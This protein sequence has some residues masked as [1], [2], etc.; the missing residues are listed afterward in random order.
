MGHTQPF[1]FV[2]LALGAVLLGV[3]V[4]C[5]ESLPS[6]AVVDVLRVIALTTE[7]PEVRPGEAVTVRTVWFDPEGR[8]VKFHWRLCREVSGFDP[9]ECAVPSVGRSLDE[10]NETVTLEASDLALEDGETTGTW[11]LWEMVCPE[12]PATVRDGRFQCSEDNGVEV[13]RRVGVRTHG[14]L[15][16]PPAIVSATI[17]DHEVTE[18]ATVTVVGCDG[19]CAPTRVSVTPANDAVEMVEGEL[20]E[21]LLLSVYVTAGSVSPVRDAAMHGELRRMSVR[22]TPPA[23]SPELR[24]WIV[25]RDQRG[26]E[27]VRIVKVR[28]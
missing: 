27:S 26:G 9:R 28:R 10:T 11:V 12:R 16:H 21:A 1:T 4:G 13:Y 23:Q 24:L 8:T 20:S 5:E 18:N 2:G 25:L 14:V 17:D 15:N 6:P 3:T 19:G 22:W 7:T